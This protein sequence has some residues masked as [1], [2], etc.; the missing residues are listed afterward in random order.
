MALSS[1]PS[2]RAVETVGPL[3]NRL[4]LKPELV[5]DLRERQLP[6]VPADAFDALVRDAWRC[7]Q[8][9]P[10][11]GE[12]NIEGQARGTAVVH[13][14][15]DRHPAEQVALATHGNL[16]ALVL[17]GLDASY[18]YEFWRQLS[19]PDVY[20]LTLDDHRLIAVER[21]WNSD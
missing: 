11:G 1:S 20:C 7:P 14:I 21:I 15:V 12:S 13:R 8:E 5:A 18:G 9:A 17:N 19:F 10:P 6:V 16:L 3:A 2:T 4:G